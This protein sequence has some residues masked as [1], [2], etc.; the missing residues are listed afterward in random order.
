MITYLDN[1]RVSCQL[2]HPVFQPKKLLKQRLAFDVAE[3]C[4]L[5]FD[6]EAVIDA[7]LQLYFSFICCIFVRAI[8]GCLYNRNLE[9]LFNTANQYLEKEL[10]E[11]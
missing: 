10:E 8:V 9:C 2:L 7:L 4:R 3:Q 11:D 1:F 5:A 6:D